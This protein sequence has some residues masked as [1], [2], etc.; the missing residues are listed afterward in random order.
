LVLGLEVA[1][2]YR[3]LLSH[4]TVLAETSHV[5]V[6]AGASLRN[7]VLDCAK[8]QSKPMTPD[9]AIAIVKSKAN[10][11][12]RYEG[13]EPFLDEVLVAEIE[14]LRHRTDAVTRIVDQLI[15]ITRLNRDEFEFSF[16]V[17]RKAAGLSW[18][19]ECRETADRHCFCIGL[20]PT[21]EDAVSKINLKEAC[22]S[23]GYVYVE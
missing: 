4:F 20:G 1:V 6:V 23:W 17:S 3:A 10:G 16:T 19:F 5:L 13:Q 9:E 7:A 12:T 8:V 15:R 14:R 22:D 2:A 21:P 18:I 11:R